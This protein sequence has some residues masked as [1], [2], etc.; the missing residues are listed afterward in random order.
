LDTKIYFDNA[1]S[2]KPDERV[3]EAML[4]YL[5]ES[6]GNPSG[7]YS[8]G[9]EARKA[10]N[11]ARNSAASFLSSE[12]DEIY[13]TS[14]GTEGNNT[15][16]LG[17]TGPSHPGMNMIISSSIEHDSV[18]RP[19]EELSRNGIGVKLIDPD[20]NGIIKPKALEDFLEK[21]SYRRNGHEEGTIRG[22]VSVMLVNN[23]TGTIQ[24]VKE[25]A[26][27]AHSYGFLFHTD[28]VQ[29]AGHMK[30]NVKELNADFLSVS[31]HKLYGPKGV[32][33]LYV[34]RGIPIK[35]Y[36]FGGGQERGL[37]SGTENVFGIVGLGKACEIATDELESSV[38]TEKEIGRYLKERL[39][40]GI[41]RASQ[42]GTGEWILNL[43][44]DRVN[45][46]S[47]AL[48]LD[49]EG[50]GISTGSACSVGLDKS[51]HVLAAMGLSK[52][53]AESSVRISIGKYNTMKEAECLADSIERLTEE[54]RSFYI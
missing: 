10:V 26:D 46:T 45:A 34:K 5:K 22:L 9:F 19:L 3:F 32:G 53:K 1:A 52:R 18:L 14:G 36:I 16:I 17:F 42:N 20:E 30:I 25:L 54:L 6:Y 39:T 40:G 21:N 29:A 24:P 37:R 44:F 51:S 43:F 33:I 13:F 15:V 27:I 11:A 38:R 49:M 12:A 7:K 4:P 2:T 35:P 28:A 41:C 8:L 23:E 47:L 48:R 50:I 31:G